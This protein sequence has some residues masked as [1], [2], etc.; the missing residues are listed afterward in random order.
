MIIGSLGL[1]NLIFFVE[2]KLLNKN[3]STNAN[4]APLF[5]Q[6]SSFFSNFKRSNFLFNEIKSF[7]KHK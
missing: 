7:F 4:S 1:K 2:D 3:S 6:N 5:N